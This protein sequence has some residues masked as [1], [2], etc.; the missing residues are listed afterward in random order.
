[1]ASPIIAAAADGTGTS[2]PD[3]REKQRMPFPKL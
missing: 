2:I 3:G 1:M